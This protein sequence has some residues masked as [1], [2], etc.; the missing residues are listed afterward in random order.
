MTDRWLIN[1]LKKYPHVNTYEELQEII[2]VKWIY[3]K[4]F[5]R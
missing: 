4:S 2:N 5:N 3:R 1:K